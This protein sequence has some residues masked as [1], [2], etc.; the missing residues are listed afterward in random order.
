[1][2]GLFLNAALT[3]KCRWKESKNGAEILNGVQNCPKCKFQY[4]LTILQGPSNWR[5]KQ[6][7]TY[8]HADSTIETTD[9][10][11]TGMLFYLNQLAAPYSCLY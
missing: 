10:V 11:T 8:K 6:K 9:G 2:A 5:R 7:Q 3:L 4:R 1:M